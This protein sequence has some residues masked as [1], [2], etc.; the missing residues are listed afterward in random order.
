MIIRIYKFLLIS[1][2][3]ILSIL[4]VIIIMFLALV[5]FPILSRPIECVEFISLPPE[6]YNGEWAARAIYENS[7]FLRDSNVNLFE[8]TAVIR[9]EVIDERRE[10]I[11]HTLESNN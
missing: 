7:R 1:T 6:R 2:I 9:G 8:G 11:R 3:T 4:A 10:A 5:V